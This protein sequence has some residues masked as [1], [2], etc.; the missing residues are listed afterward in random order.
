MGDEWDTN[1]TA[2]LNLCPI[3]HPKSNLSVFGKLNGS[4]NC[5]LNSNRK[6]KNYLFWRATNHLFQIVNKS[7]RNEARRDIEFDC[8]VDS[9]KAMPFALGAMFLREQSK[10]RSSKHLVETMA[11]SIK[12]A[13]KENFSNLQWLDHETRMLLTKKV[14]DIST[15]IGKIFWTFI[16]FSIYW[17]I[18]CECC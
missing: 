15:L 8:A 17:T 2:L 14:D 4:S 11:E 16:L 13:F 10:I 6:L 5:I 12:E 3:C 7:L 1:W 9:A 18:N